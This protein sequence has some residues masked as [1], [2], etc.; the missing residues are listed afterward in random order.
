MTLQ[1]SIGI[2]GSA[3]GKVLLYAFLNAS[4]ESGFTN[5][6]DE[7]IRDCRGIDIS[8]YRK[9][10]EI[11]YDFVRKRLTVL[12]EASGSALMV[13]KGAV[14]RVLSVCSMAED[15]DG[16]MLQ[17]A[18][19]KEDL[20]RRYRE[21]SSQGFRLLG[22]A[23]KKF[24]KLERLS[25][26]LEADMVFLG[27]LVFFDPPKKGVLQA[28]NTLED[29]GI[30]FKMI[31]GDNRFVAAHVSRQIGLEHPLVLT[32]QAILKMSDEALTRKVNDVDVF[33]EVEPN[34]K[35]RIVL[36]L[37]KAG[38]VVGYMGDGI[39]DASALHA[40]DAGVSVDT[41]L[42]VVKDA[43]D[44]VLLEKGLDVLA[45]GVQEGRNIF[46]NT[47]KYVMISTSANFGNMFSM[48]CVSPFLPFLPLLPKQ[49]LLNNLLTDIP[50]MAIADDRVDPEMVARPRR[51]DIS[52]IRRF[53]VIFGLQS[54]LFDLL[55]FAVLLYVL[56][57][58]AGEFRTGWFL[59]SAISEILIL[60]VIRTR[61]PFF[62]SLPGRY[63][64][65]AGLV[66]V[67]TAVVF[68]LP[69]LGEFMGFDTIPGIY[70]AA[71][72]AILGLYVATAELTKKI[73]FRTSTG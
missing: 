69:P 71:L 54:S 37:K 41:A 66:M 48:A 57:A 13:T 44:I 8:P 29:L 61:R 55:T 2:N 20:H 64:S 49:I 63:L 60:L 53:M 18:Q 27:F 42:A 30:N 58:A 56:H 52:Q 34:Q 50:A 19:V 22:V 11:P 46:A 33:A 1:E 67:A 14:E 59:E 40:A 3:S 12:L 26:D 4:F 10:G 62:R 35:E 70:A 73:F 65:L 17:L 45:S 7:A 9:I 28:V 72:L 68:V 36:A 23:C 5:P 25:G 32:G 24:E 47:L 38:N 16:K 6:M 43:A 39:N 15:S 51:W 31:T 21:I